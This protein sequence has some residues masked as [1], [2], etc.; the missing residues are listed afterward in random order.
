M[1]EYDG[2]GL[3]EEEIAALEEADADEKDAGDVAGGQ[4]DP[5]KDD[6]KGDT[7]KDTDK[8]TGDG[9]DKGGKEDK[10][11]KDDDAAKVAADAGDKGKVDADG[12]DKG[13][14]EGEEEDKG[15]DEE[16]DL[17]TPPSSGKM[18]PLV[19]AEGAKARIDEITTELEGI[20]AKYE[21]GTYDVDEYNAKREG[22]VREQTKIE[23]KIEMSDEFQKA[24]VQANWQGAQDYYLSK[25]PEVSSD[26]NLLSMFAA[27][28]NKI[29][30]TEEGAAMG[31]YDILK[32]AYKKMA[33]LIPDD[34]KS[35]AQK[36]EE[37]KEA[38][39][40]AAKKTAADKARAGAPKTL[41]G[42]SSAEGNEEEG[43]FAHLEGLTGEALERAM[44]K[45]SEAEMEEYGREV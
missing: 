42:V 45:M 22:L 19:D 8:G 16:E 34:K 4:D 29:L 2:L 21:D 44:E 14:K 28:V 13:K 35:D 3:S 43:K 24:S 23:A 38:L 36:K 31:D 25:H 1:G 9:D 10:D 6:D 40:K 5:N 17:E 18:G 12:D 27:N 32:A 41:T 37:E 11:D 39:I 26:E 30:A 15:K 20:K 7:G 33:Y